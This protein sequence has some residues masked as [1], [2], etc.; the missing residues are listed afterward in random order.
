MESQGSRFQEVLAEGTFAVTM[1]INPPKGTHIT[2]ILE[3]AKELVGKVH[4]INVTDNTGAIVR[5]GSLGVCRL[6]YELGHDPIL[7]MTS[8]DRNRIGLQSDL[9]SAHVL[10]IRNVLC[11]TGDPPSVGDHKDAKPVFDVDSVTIMKMIRGL[12]QC[13]DLAGN[14]LDGGTAFCIGG[15]VAPGFDAREV[16]HQ[17]LRAKIMAG[18]QFFQTQAVF[19][20][21]TFREFLQDIRQHQ[22]KILAGILVLRSTKM[23]NFLNA[24]IPGIEVPQSLIQELQ[25]AG[26]KH[27]K[28]AGIEIAVRTIKAIRPYCDGIHLMTARGLDV[29][30]QILHKADLVL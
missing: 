24:N 28:E 15:A 3:T 13:R 11:L 8:R 26:P 17:K 16:M 14:V 25:D 2:D 19:C 22:Q 30:P 10:G 5:V 9:L 21:D 12:N 18:A 1:E 27:E 6:L 29:I 4:A 20:L 23:A 7:Q